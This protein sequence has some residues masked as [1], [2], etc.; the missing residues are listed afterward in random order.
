MTHSYFNSAFTTV[1]DALKTGKC[2]LITERDGLQGP[3]GSAT[4]QGAPA[5]LYI[6]R[7]T[8]EPKE[9]RAR[10]GRCSARRR[11]SRRAS[12]S[13]RRASI[14]TGSANS[15]GVLG[16]YLM[17]HIW[18]AGGA[19]RRVP[20]CS[21]TKPS[22]NSPRRPSGIYVI[23]FRNTKNGARSKDFLRGYGFQGGGNNSFNFNVPGYGD[24][25][26]KA[27]LDAGVTSVGFAGFGEMLPRFENKVELICGNRGRRGASPCSR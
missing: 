12:C 23:R 9:V 2:T 22:L 3:D 6:D 14:R 21:G 5:S 16:H 27:I 17:D 18:V 20:G 7:V 24:A 10:D 4:G 26:K 11:S 15:S 8:R 1:A 13:T 25:Y 19:Q